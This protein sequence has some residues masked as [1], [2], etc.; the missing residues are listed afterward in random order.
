MLD[1]GLTEEQE[2]FRQEIAEFCKVELQGKARTPELTDSFVRKA[3][4]KGWAGVSIPEEY[5]GLGRDAM[6]RVI[7]N[8]EMAYNRAPVPLSLWGRS[9]ML[10]GKICL[11]H[12]SEEQKR[13]Y[14]PQI[15]RGEDIG[16]CYTEPEAGTDMTR[17]QTRAVRE[18]DNYV[19]NGQKMFI[20]TTHFVRH[21][22]LMARTDPD[23][24]PEKGL[25]MFILDNT[26]PG[27]TISPLTG[28]GYFR[29]NHLF[30]D[31]VQ[32]P[33]WNRVG[34]ENRGFDYFLED[35]PFYFHKEQGATVG[36]ARRAF[37]DLAQY[38]KATKRSGRLLSQNP[39][40]R[41]KLAE[42]ATRIGAMR[43]LIYRMAWME[44]QGLD[45]SDIATIARV[46]DVETRTE[47]N[48]TAMR[49]LGL[50][51]QLGPGSEYAPLGGMT[52]WRYQSDGL[53]YF[54]RGSPSYA[55][56]VIATHGLGMPEPW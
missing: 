6:Y 37:D 20:S 34:E 16:Q 12:G 54:T 31:D 52:E 44:D 56:S 5:G 30:L 29:T 42:M 41:Q 4:D 7:F 21:T 55:K 51:G 25:S 49:L 53:Q 15:A 8:E 11:K 24:P 35:K 2:D 17:I 45:V 39:V 50:N 43:L 40:V 26:S 48:S 32:V 13:Q 23:A 10:F 33:A 22:L 47:F 27:I 36:D 9:F 18:G 3:I 1:F 19:I 28:M 38:A 14:L 46:F